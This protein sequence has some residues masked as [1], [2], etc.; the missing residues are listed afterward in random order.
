[1]GKNLSFAV[2]KKATFSKLDPFPSSAERLG[3]T[4]SVGSVTKNWTSDWD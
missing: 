2:P 4:Y 1:M 3:G